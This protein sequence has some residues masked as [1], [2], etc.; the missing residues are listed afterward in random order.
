MEEPVRHVV[1]TLAQLRRLRAMTEEERLQLGRG[2]TEAVLYIARE[3]RKE[4]STRST[5]TL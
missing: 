4:L 2:L 1:T 5:G 3:G